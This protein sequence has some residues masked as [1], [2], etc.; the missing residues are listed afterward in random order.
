M[1]VQQSGAHG[2]GLNSQVN[3]TQLQF[4][5]PHNGQRTVNL[6]Q[7]QHEAAFSIQ[8]LSAVRTVSVTP[9]LDQVF[10][11][12]QY[13]KCICQEHKCQGE[14]VVCRNKTL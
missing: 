3:P 7:V 9:A 11:H 13:D 1:N 14:G 10:A 4:V 2:K 5:S 12:A 8:D 6:R